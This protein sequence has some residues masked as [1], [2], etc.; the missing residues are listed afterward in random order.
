MAYFEKIKQFGNPG[1]LPEGWFWLERS[2]AIKTGKAYPIKFL[3]TDLVLYRG[4][5]GVVRAFDAH[6]PHMGAHL[7]DGFVEK[8]SIRC[9]FHFWKYD[10]NGVCTEIPAQ[11]DTSKISKLRAHKVKEQYG[12]IWIWTGSD[13]DQEEIPVIPEIRGMPLDYMMGSRFIK[14]CSPNV[15][16]IN[17][18]D[19]QHFRSVHQ[20]IVDLDMKATPLSERCIQFSNI[21]DIPEKN[22][23]LK[24]AKRFYKK[25]LTYE[26]TYWWGHIGT[27]MVGPDFL[28]FYIMFALRPTPDGKTE[29]QTILIT[30]KRKGLAGLILNPIVLFISKL[31]ADHFAKGDTII[32]SRIKFKYQTPIKAD[33]AIIDFIEHYEL[34][35]AGLKY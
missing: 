28:H 18:I 3:N 32:F 31:V 10:E 19:I 30:K 27:V 4:E 23:L 17:A 6:C 25:C 5:D 1:F 12:L 20:M 35:N 26:L 9:P 21:T 7:C 11:K 8:N 14:N 2:S 13:E 34:Q 33:K 22:F 15:V 24:F 29:G 16:M